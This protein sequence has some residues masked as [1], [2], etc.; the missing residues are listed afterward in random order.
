[1]TVGEQGQGWDKPSSAM[2]VLRHGKSGKTNGLRVRVVVIR[3]PESDVGLGVLWTID[4]LYWLVFALLLVWPWNHIA[5]KLGHADGV[6][7]L[8]ED[9]THSRRLSQNCVD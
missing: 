6:T 8:R 2:V 4:V 7:L 3:L 1:M 5:G 9:E